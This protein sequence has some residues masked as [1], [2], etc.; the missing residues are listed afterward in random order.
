VSAAQADLL[1][2][3]VHAGV[4]MDPLGDDITTDPHTDKRRPHPRTTRSQCRKPRGIWDNC[5]TALFGLSRV[6]R[7]AL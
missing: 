3:A 4:Q 6:L 7:T 1:Q 5:V 2:L